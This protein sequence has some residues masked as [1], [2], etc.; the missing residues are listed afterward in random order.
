MKPCCEDHTKID[1]R[2]VDARGREIRREWLRSKWN[3]YADRLVDYE[4]RRRGMLAPKVYTY[5]N[6]SPVTFTIPDTEHFIPGTVI[7]LEY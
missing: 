2:E 3:D 5:V 1:C 7:R 6:P 4:R